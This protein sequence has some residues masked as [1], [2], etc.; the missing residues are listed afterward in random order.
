MVYERIIFIGADRSIVQA[1]AQRRYSTKA[2]SVVI[3]WFILIFLTCRYFDHINLY[4]TN[5]L[6]SLAQTK[7]VIKTTALKIL[8]RHLFADDF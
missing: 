6:I 5:Y 2:L 8:A 7:P 4:K 1:N 3:S